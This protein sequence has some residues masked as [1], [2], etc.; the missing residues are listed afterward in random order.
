MINRKKASVKYG[1]TLKP[2]IQKIYCVYLFIATV[3]GLYQSFSYFLG[4]DFR[5]LYEAQASLL[6]SIV[7]IVSLIMI[8]VSIIFL[9]LFIKRGESKIYIIF[10]S[11]FI[12]FYLFLFFILDII[13]FGYYH[14]NQALHII[15]K[16]SRY[17]II[18]YLL[19]VV[20]STFIFC[21]IQKLKSIEKSIAAAS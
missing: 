1:K 9:V 6:S 17:D 10:P 2:N 15:E 12:I 14:P 4:R 19:G 11:Y 16:I 18:F 13:I 7:V 8:V 3:I 5:L 21:K 20:L